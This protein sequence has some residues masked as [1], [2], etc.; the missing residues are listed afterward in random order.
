MK[1]YLKSDAEVVLEVA[2]R[3]RQMR[4]SQNLTQAQVAERSLIPISTLRLFEKE[5]RI[6]LR[7]LVALAAVLGCKNDFDGLFHPP[8]AKNLADLIPNTKTRQRAR[9]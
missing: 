8:A 5:G 3:L 2:S 7:Q 6:S 9:P 4:L 1:L